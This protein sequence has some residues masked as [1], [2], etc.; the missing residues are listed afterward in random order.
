MKQGDDAFAVWGGISGVQS[1]LPLL[2]DDERLDLETVVRLAAT[3]PAVRFGLPGKG[4]IE[5][6][7]DADLALVALDDPWT[8]ERADLRDRHGHSPYVGRRFRS[9]VVR[10]LVR[11]GAAGGR[12]V[13]PA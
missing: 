4:R 13:R 6:G 1:T 12:L 8:L 10:T 5:P 7:A 11:G 3:A 9:R 2:L